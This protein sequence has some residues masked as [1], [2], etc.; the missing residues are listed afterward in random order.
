MTSP[1]RG[2]LSWKPSLEGPGCFRS[3]RSNG[4]TLALC[5]RAQGFGPVSLSTR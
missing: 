4:H 3:Q 5:S 1:A 2:K